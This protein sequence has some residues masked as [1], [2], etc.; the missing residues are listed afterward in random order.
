M[1]FNSVRCSSSFCGPGGYDRRGA[2][3]A[4][5]A[6]PPLQWTDPDA[7][8]SPLFKI[9]L[10]VLAIMLAAIFTANTLAVIHLK[11]WMEPV[12]V[13]VNLNSI[14]AI[15][16]DTSE[17]RGTFVDVVAKRLRS[18]V[19]AD[20]GTTVVTLRVLDFP[21][22]YNE[23]DGLDRERLEEHFG[24]LTAAQMR[25]E[26]GIAKL[27]Q[28][29]LDK[30]RA[31]RAEIRLSVFGLPVNGGDPQLANERYADLLK[32]LNAFVTVRPDRPESED[33]HSPPGQ[34]YLDGCVTLAN[35]RAIYYLDCDAWMLAVGT[36]ELNESE[37]AA[38]EKAEAQ[39][40]KKAKKR[41][42]KRRPT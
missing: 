29:I 27:L 18:A 40:K 38:I 22:R 4:K 25:Y 32:I 39:R 24:G 33:D 26:G 35:G 12:F 11:P 2:P 36:V 6:L 13:D 16:E 9:I 10:A 5:S 37:M 15:L 1:R 3:P 7:P 23:L 28:A 14:D 20:D 17:S 21:L 30:A 31:D 41:A 42:V 19:K 34:R 8:V